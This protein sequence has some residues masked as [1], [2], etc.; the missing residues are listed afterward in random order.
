V[1]ASQDLDWRLAKL[2]TFF[3]SF[4]PDTDDRTGEAGETRKAEETQEA[5]EVFI[6]S[7]LWCHNVIAE[8]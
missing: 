8:D 6:D 4:Y 5:N 7:Q 3:R 2:V 1:V